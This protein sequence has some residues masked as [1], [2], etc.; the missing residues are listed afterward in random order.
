METADIDRILVDV[1]GT[2]CRNLPRVCEFLGR[3]YGVDVSP[4]EITDWRHRFDSIDRG[5]DDVI[6]RLLD[7]QP[8]WFLSELDPADGAPAALDALAAAGYEIHIA[9][10]RPAHTHDITRRWLDD[11]GIS[12]DHFVAD[13]PANK[14][15]L[16]GDALVDDFHGNVTDAVEA[17]YVGVLFERPYSE[18]VQR[19]GAVT[20]STWTE[21]LDTFG[22]EG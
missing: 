21:V 6:A 17:G 20:V 22:V 11:H 13:V 7:D 9:T 2:V 8:E 15:E 1:D 18:P 19:P 4:A 14:A 12:Y 3:E 10:H 16:P 5:V